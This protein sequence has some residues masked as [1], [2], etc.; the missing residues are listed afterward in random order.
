MPS[1]ST[2]AAATLDTLLAERWSCRAFLPDPLPQALVE[3]I[4]AAA[5]RTPSWCNTQPW[6]LYVTDGAAT[7]RVRTA[8]VEAVM[9]DQSETP[10]LAFPPGYEGE[11]R[12]RRRACGWALYDAVGVERGDRMASALQAL[13]NFEL[14]GAPHLAVLTTPRSLGTY[15]AVDCGLFLQSFLLSAQARGVA[16]IAQAALAGKSAVL[17]EQLGIPDEEQVLVGVSFGWPDPDHPA[18]GFRT[19]RVEVADVLTWRS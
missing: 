5:G 8:L 1:E 10:D 3:E 16:T 2:A 12:E 6:R 7:D 15:G 17:R 4:V 18:N 11:F 9:A 13:K 19:E 14:F